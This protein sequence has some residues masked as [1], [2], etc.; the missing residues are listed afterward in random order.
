MQLW[1][2]RDVVAMRERYKFRMY[3]EGRKEKIP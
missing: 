3:F 1:G 2:S